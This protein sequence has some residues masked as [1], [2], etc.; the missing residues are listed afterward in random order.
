IAIAGEPGPVLVELPVNLQLFP[1]D[2][3]VLT[4]Y[5]PPPPAP[6][7]AAEA[8]GA[9]AGFLLAA[10]RPGIFLGWGA[11]GAG[12]EAAAIAEFLQAPVSTTLQGLSAFSAR[13]PL[14]TGFSFGE[15]AVP[16][17]KNAFADCDALLAVGT[18]FGELATGSF[19]VRVPEYLVHIDINPK[20]LNR[21]YP[22]R[23]AIEADARTALVA[24][25][26]E[27]HRRGA[28]RPADTRLVAAIHEDKRRYRAQ[29][30]AHDSKG[31]VNPARFFD[32]LR[33]AL[34]DDAITTVD[35]GNHTYLT[36]ELFPVYGPK[37]LIV[38]TDFNCMGYAVPAAIGAKFAHP[39]REVCSIVGD[40][41][42]L[43]T[44]M[45]ILSATANGLGIV[46]Y[47]FNDGSLSQIAQA[48]EIP[49]HRTPCSRLGPVRF[50]AMALATG[51]AYV[52]MPEDAAIGA[53]IDAAR[54]IAAGG[55]P[56]IVD[57]AI[58][59]SK[60]TA[61]TRGAVKVNFKRFPLAQRLRMAGRALARRVTG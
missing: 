41:A 32:A 29:W 42:F 57:V 50:E 28:P 22:A 13:H 18:R 37:T 30:L 4:D 26:A 56:V 25:L 38:P 20:V 8:I 33:A 36:A 15:A 6:T 17:A 43:M 53:A 14:H 55:R 10:K 58:D 16:A 5:L 9:A 11:N 51:A 19:G 1:G 61:F 3:G 52:A 47:V 7:P 45:E 48:Q 60:R 31:R 34:P 59:Y 54:R 27:L 44:G 49:Y 35:D 39:A 24:L 21:N 23:I 40:G 12:A 46:Y 2:A